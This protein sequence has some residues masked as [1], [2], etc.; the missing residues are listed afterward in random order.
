MVVEGNAYVEN[1]RNVEMKKDTAATVAPYGH[2]SLALYTD[3]PRAMATML[4][5]L[6]SESTGTKACLFRLQNPN[7]SDAKKTKVCHTTQ[8]A[9]PG[10]SE[11]ACFDR[12]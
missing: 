1:R 4:L 12:G 10:A 7:A 9:L 3:L 2:S 6:R 5:A 11:D 8:P